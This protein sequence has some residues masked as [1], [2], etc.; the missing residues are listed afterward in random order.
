[1][2]PDE[3]RKHATV[4]ILNGGRDHHLFE[5]QDQITGSDHSWSPPT[6]DIAAV[7]DAV[8]TATITVDW[9][10]VERPVYLLWSNKH[11]MWWRAD[12]GGYTEDRSQAGRYTRTDAAEWCA[13]SAD[14]GIISHVTCMVHMGASS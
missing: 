11:S 4:L 8:R 6:E 2:D 12:A 1:M 7:E 14:H 9:P 3:I 10:E 13:N 5:Y